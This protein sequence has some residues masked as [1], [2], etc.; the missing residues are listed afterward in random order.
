MCEQILQ[1][2]M[3]AWLRLFVGIIGVGSGGGGLGALPPSQKCGKAEV[4]FRTPQ[5]KDESPLFVSL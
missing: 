4:C 1:S 5:S 3:R 2:L